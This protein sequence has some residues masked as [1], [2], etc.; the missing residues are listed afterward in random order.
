MVGSPRLSGVSNAKPMRSDLVSVSLLLLFSGGLVGGC[1]G[2][3]GDTQEPVTPGDSISEPKAAKA[4][5]DPSESEARAEIADA[6]GD[7][8]VT[9]IDMAGADGEP[10]P[11]PSV[12]AQPKRPPMPSMLSDVVTG[13]SGAAPGG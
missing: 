5:V 13:P 6:T 2:G 12:V 8:N 9:V 10:E 4:E 1:A 3:R 11:S 7:P